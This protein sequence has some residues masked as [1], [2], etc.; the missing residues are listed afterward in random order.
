[1]SRLLAPAVVMVVAAALSA[2]GTDNDGAAS[3]A[4]EQAWSA[5]WSASAQRPAAGFGPNWSEQGFSGESV[6]QIVR[7]TNGGDKAR[8]RLSNRFGAGPLEVDGAT[9]A[10]HLA[11]AA[12]EPES[13]RPLTFGGAKRVVI[14]PGAEMSSD[15]AE[16]RVAPLESVAVTLYFAG[17]TGPATFHSQA[18]TDT[19]RA[20]GDHAADTG[21]AAFTERTNSWYYLT[22][23]EV[24]G[25]KA[26]RDTV[27][28]LG[29]SITDGFGSTT[30]AN[31]RYTDALADRLAASGKQR[32]VLNQGIGGNLVVNDSAWYGERA[33]TRFDRDVLAK[34]GVRSVIILE[35][36][37]DIGFSET[38]KPTY[39]PSADVSAEQ[40]I[41][42][43]RTLIKQAHARGIKAIGATLLPFGDSDHYSARAAAKRHTINTWIRT[44]GEY[45][46]V[47]DFD[48]ALA[49]PT[50][51]EKIATP[52]DSG[53]HL[54][55]NDHGYRAMAATID[56]EKL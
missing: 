30:G 29:D 54:H 4:A 28:S 7:V 14:P 11:E 49:D 16:L 55:P 15:A 24:S 40:I 41:A 39:K 35:G 50:N 2:C 1:M 33:A 45:D 12:T 47:V 18:W 31:Q 5:A 52:Y 43:Y 10:V 53:D 22:D 56:L 34:P 23:V 51:P 13:L 46:A 26:R 32:A 48:R 8:I 6:R 3:S 38:D 9:I 17:T 20:A 36:V 37:N 42:G 19:Y 27:V 44:S 21:A 25:G